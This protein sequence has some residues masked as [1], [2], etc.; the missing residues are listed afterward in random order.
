M[1]REGADAKFKA[2]TPVSTA[3]STL[4]INSIMFD[5]HREPT[6]FRQRGAA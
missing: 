6:W 3:A 1:T 5:K 4:S 2:A